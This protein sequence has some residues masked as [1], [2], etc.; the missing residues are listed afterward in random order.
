MPDH[1][2]FATLL[3]DRL[4]SMD[5]TQAALAAELTKRSIETTRQAVHDWCQGKSRPEPWKWSTLLDALA[6]PMA[7]RPRWEEALKA[8]R[9][10]TV[11]DAAA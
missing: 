1:A 9:T 11:N 2:T 6:I 3:S 5:S 8:R 4:D 10:P 7:E